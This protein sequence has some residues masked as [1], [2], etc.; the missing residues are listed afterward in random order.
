MQKVM[1]DSIFKNITISTSKLK[2]LGKA[3]EMVVFNYLSS[4]AKIEPE[5][6]F[7]I[8]EDKDYKLP[9]STF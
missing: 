9:N 3:R 2:E 4:I 1:E 8:S 7:I 5:R 6:I